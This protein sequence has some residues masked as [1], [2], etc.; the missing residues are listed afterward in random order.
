MTGKRYY[1]TTLGGWQRHAARFAN[2]HFIVLDAL[3]PSD[4]VIPGESA[5]ADDDGSAVVSNEAPQPIPRT[6][7]ISPPRNNAAEALSAAAEVRILALIEADEGVH[8][9]LEDDHAFDPLP[10]PLA[11]T[12][13]S[14]AAQAALA[15]HGVAPGATTFDAMETLARVHPLLRHRVF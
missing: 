14:D 10:H 12:P 4:V 9:A 1:I 8:L 15:L 13:I 6:E 7:A 2:S 5:P 3:T 11:Q